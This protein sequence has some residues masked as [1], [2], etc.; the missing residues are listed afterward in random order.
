M[1]YEPFIMTEYMDHLGPDVSKDLT[2]ST[3]EVW[4]TEE[5]L[6]LD[7]KDVATAL[8]TTMDYGP[9]DGGAE[10]RGA[11]AALF[12]H[13]SADD[14]IVTHGGAEAIF[15]SLSGL[16]S[17]GDHAII[18]TPCFQPLLSVARATGAEVS[19]WPALESESWIPSLA[20]L[21]ALL[22]DATRVVVINTPHNPSGVILNEAFLGR[23]NTLAAERD[24]VVISD[25]I[26]RWSERDDS[27]RAPAAVDLDPRAITLG[28]L[29]K[30]FGMPGVRI[31]WIAVRDAQLR[32][33]IYSPKVYTTRNMNPVS[34]ML[35]C[36][37]LRHS[38]EILDR[39]RRLLLENGEKLDA[40]VTRSANRVKRIGGEATP[41]IFL[42]LRGRDADEFCARAA[43]QAKLALLPGSM[44]GDYPTHIRVGYGTSGFEDSLNRLEQFLAQ[45]D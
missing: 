39:N 31:G 34:I 8:N 11:I 36:I 5:L 10:L 23:L 27:A 4:S 9:T 16:L 28:G 37:A 19:E 22:T 7:G 42:E 38:D 15:L 14:I 29:S 26:F 20:R 45:S 6:A 25:E 1:K 40:F 41:V 35:A 18:H 32:A 24:F 2:G 13:L 30:S 33:R 12:E 21:E 43:Q 44:F 17:S 3:C